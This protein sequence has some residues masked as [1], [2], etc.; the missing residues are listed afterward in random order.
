MSSPPTCT[1]SE[2]GN[3]PMSDAPLATPSARRRLRVFG[4]TLWPSFLVAGVATMIFFANVDPESL[5]SQTLPDWDFGRRLGYT[6]GF[7]MF[8]GVCAA[9]SALTLLLLEGSGGGRR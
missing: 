5:R 7:F 3:P 6:I 9:S 2:G 1:S 8:W 4:A